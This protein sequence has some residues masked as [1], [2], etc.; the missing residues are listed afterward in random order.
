VTSA[1][2][3]L[4]SCIPYLPFWRF[5]DSALNAVDDALDSASELKKKP[6]E[7]VDKKFATAIEVLCRYEKHYHAELMVS[8]DKHVKTVYE[9][10]DAAKT[11][12]EKLTSTGLNVLKEACQKVRLA[13]I[14]QPDTNY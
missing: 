12:D 7:E 4:R 2:N 11:K 5:L 3:G 10:M 6:S 13:I 8:D 9:R 14:T 1:C